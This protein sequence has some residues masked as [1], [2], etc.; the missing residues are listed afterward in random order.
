MI[1]HYVIGM[2]SSACGSREEQPTLLTTTHYILPISLHHP[3]G[4]I[5]IRNE[6]GAFLAIENDNKVKYI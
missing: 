5:A 6:I 4:M 3:M 2:S 1:Y